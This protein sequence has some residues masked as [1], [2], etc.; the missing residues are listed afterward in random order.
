[1]HS[2][3]SSCPEGKR[4]DWTPARQ[5][6]AALAAPHRG[7]SPAR[8]TFSLITARGGHGRVRPR[9]LEHLGRKSLTHTSASRGLFRLLSPPASP[10][11]YELPAGQVL[12]AGHLLSPHSRPTRPH[13]R[14]GLKVLECV[15]LAHFPSPSAPSRV[16][17]AVFPS[18]VLNQ[19]RTNDSTKMLRVGWR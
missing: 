19:G 13:G 2:P 3:L 7:P 6:W 8:T 5:L 16:P 12:P 18:L 9:N 1:M 17:R 14:G 4:P 11:K 15:S 10:Q